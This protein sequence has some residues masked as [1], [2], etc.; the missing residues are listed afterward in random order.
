[1]D[2]ELQ[3]T[4]LLMQNATGIRSRTRDTACIQVSRCPVTLCSLT[5]I[6]LIFSRKK[7]V[8]N[9]SNIVSSYFLKRLTI[10]YS[11]AKNYVERRMAETFKLMH[12]T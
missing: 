9:V 2:T 1:M 7:P 5:R 8:F 3:L 4:I 11:R 6:I 12:S 10:Y